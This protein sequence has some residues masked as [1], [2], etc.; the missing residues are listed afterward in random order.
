MLG[1]DKERHWGIAPR[2]VLKCIFIC[3][4]VTDAGIAN[5]MVTIYITL[6]RILIL[7]VLS[8]LLMGGKFYHNILTA[9]RT[10]S[11]QADELFS[12][13]QNLMRSKIYTITYP[14]FNPLVLLW[15]G[16]GFGAETGRG[17]FSRLPC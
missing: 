17:R 1:E 4:S 2:L 7:P 5:M 8:L 14:H 15:P 16:N 9:P 13:Y 6:I 11:C 3:E 12:V 10:V